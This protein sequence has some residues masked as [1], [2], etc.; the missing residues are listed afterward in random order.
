MTAFLRT[1]FARAPWRFSP[2]EKRRQYQIFLWRNTNAAQQAE[3]EL[4]ALAYLHL[5]LICECISRIS[6]CVV[7]NCKRNEQKFFFSPNAKSPIRIQ[8]ETA[9][10]ASR[11]AL[12]GGERTLAY[13]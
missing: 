8:P 5:P 11:L 13:S 9:V 12:R 2:L 7:S 1:Q 6:Y 4:K 10:R 3:L